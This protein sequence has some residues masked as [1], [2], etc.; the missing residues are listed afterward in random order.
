MRVRGIFWGKD[1]VC[2]LVGFV[3]GKKVLGVKASWDFGS[4]FEKIEGV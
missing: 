1:D 3:K 4:F 2:R